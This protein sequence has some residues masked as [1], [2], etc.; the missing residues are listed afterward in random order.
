[1]T[2]GYLSHPAVSVA[3][4]V[5]AGPSPYELDWARWTC[6]PVDAPNRHGL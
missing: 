4:E 6:S 1:M 2:G 3:G 5:L